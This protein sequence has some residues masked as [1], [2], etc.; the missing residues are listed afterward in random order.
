MY[1]SDLIEAPEHSRNFNRSETKA[2][3][4]RSSTFEHFPVT[5]SIRWVNSL[6]ALQVNIFFYNLG[7]R[8]SHVQNTVHKKAFFASFFQVI[9]YFPGNPVKELKK[10]SYPK[11]QKRERGKNRAKFSKISAFL[12]G[13]WCFKRKFWTCFI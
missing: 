1:S 3:E 9:C 5:S 10:L 7:W 2:G 8:Y 13:H 11:V 6:K 4:N 12:K